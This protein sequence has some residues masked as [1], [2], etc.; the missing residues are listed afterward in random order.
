MKEFGLVGLG[1]AILVGSSC[2]AERSFL[3]P[4]SGGPPMHD[5]VDQTMETP[6]FAPRHKLDAGGDSRSLG[7]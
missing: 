7:D 4:E 1:L 6:M 5:Q 3:G 2:A